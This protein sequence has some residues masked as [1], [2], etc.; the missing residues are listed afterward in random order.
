[1]LVSR[2]YHNLCPYPMLLFSLV[3]LPKLSTL[4]LLIFWE[5][6]QFIVAIY[7]HLLCPPLLSATSVF[8]WPK[9]SY[10]ISW[11]PW[12]HC[13]T[14][15]SSLSPNPYGRRQIILNIF[16]VKLLLCM[17]IF[18]ILSSPVAFGFFSLHHNGRFVCA[19]IKYFITHVVFSLPISKKI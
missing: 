15:V 10:H 17:Q 1:M 18:L 14:F 3:V 8:F 16:F 2:V 12:S 7:D 6:C 19:R 4:H 9:R 11:Y 5:F 13:L